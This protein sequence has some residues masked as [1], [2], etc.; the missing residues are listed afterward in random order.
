MEAL[1]AAI[2]E[3]DFCTALTQVDTLART[4]HDPLIPMYVNSIKAC[5]FA[6]SGHPAAYAALSHAL[7]GMTPELFHYNASNLLLV[8]RVLGADGYIGHRLPKD[9]PCSLSDFPHLARYCLATRNYAGVD[10]LLVQI[11]KISK[12]FLGTDPAMTGMRQKEALAVMVSRSVITLLKDSVDNISTRNAI[13]LFKLA[14]SSFSKQILP[15]IALFGKQIPHSGVECIKKLHRQAPSSMVANL[16][17]YDLVLGLHSEPGDWAPKLLM[18]DEM[19][20]GIQDPSPSG[21]PLLESASNLLGRLHTVRSLFIALGHVNTLKDAKMTVFRHFWKVFKVEHTLDALLVCEAVDND[22]WLPRCVIGVLYYG[23]N[24]VDGIEE[25]DL[26]EYQSLLTGPDAH[27]STSLL[28]DDTLLQFLILLAHTPFFRQEAL[29]RNAE[30]LPTEE[31]ERETSGEMAVRID[32]I[33]AVKHIIRTLIDRFQASTV[34]SAILDELVKTILLFRYSETG[35]ELHNMMT[36]LEYVI[37][38]DERYQED[39]ILHLVHT[40][41]QVIEIYLVLGWDARGAVLHPSL[42]ALLD[43]LTLKSLQEA[44]NMIATAISDLLYR[45]RDFNFHIDT[46][47]ITT[48]TG[49]LIAC[50]NLLQ[51]RQFQELVL[52][53]SGRCSTPDRQARD[54]SINSSVSSLQVQLERSAANIQKNIMKED[55]S[56]EAQPSQRSSSPLLMVLPEEESTQYPET[57]A[58]LTALLIHLSRYARLMFEH[59]KLLYTTQKGVID[60]Y[61]SL[62]LVLLV[63]KQRMRTID[64]ACWR[65]R[66]EED[67]MFTFLNIRNQSYLTLGYVVWTWYLEM[68]LL[69]ERQA[70][71]VFDGLPDVYIEEHRLK[72]KPSKSTRGNKRDASVET[73]Q[74]PLGS[75]QNPFLYPS[76]YIEM[77]SGANADI[78]TFGFVPYVQGAAQY[79]FEFT[80][81]VLQGLS[82]GLIETINPAVLLDGLGAIARAH[83]SGSAVLA[84]ALHG[85]YKWIGTMLS[86]KSI[87][88]QNLAS[89]FAGTSGPRT[90]AERPLSYSR[91]GSFL[92]DSLDL[93]PFG[94]MSFLFDV[95]GRIDEDVPEME[96][97][98]SGPIPVPDHPLGEEDGKESMEERVDIP[99]A[100]SILPMSN[101]ILTTDFWKHYVQTTTIPIQA[102]S[103]GGLLLRRRPNLSKDPGFSRAL[104]DGLRRFLY[105][106]PGTITRRMSRSDSLGTFLVYHLCLHVY[107]VCN[108][109]AIE[110]NSCELGE[111]FRQANALIDRK[112]VWDEEA[113]GIYAEYFDYHGLQHRLPPIDLFINIPLVHYWASRAGAVIGSCIIPEV[114]KLRSCDFTVSLPLVLALASSIILLEGA[115]APDIHQNLERILSCLSEK[116]VHPR[117]ETSRNIFIACIRNLLRMRL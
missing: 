95:G 46:L 3:H 30:C 45:G 47:L 5:I 43:D 106:V 85:L 7:T 53:R 96:R 98:I 92:I 38:R 69:S 15:N 80:T 31:I 91:D 8:C 103:V 64:T 104:G 37:R 58:N 78:R 81:D 112:G 113:P 114:I 65:E 90:S 105:G 74:F 86:Y 71:S 59:L 83:L 12:K 77:A 89:A 36:V 32:V 33:T 110:A 18:T 76:N 93:N 26:N 39:N 11:D 107:L 94:L 54:F 60:A 66:I 62:P 117:Q 21:R 101:S 57:Q 88:K 23:L 82:L 49:M 6:Y 108:G 10:K 102:A 13:T 115:I 29:P 40:Y 87:S 75:S 100:R 35:L 97:N 14:L 50:L 67:I 44:A 42:Q 20:M 79:P 17:E 2:D 34:S 19:L 4:S 109:L 111:L 27:A 73:P 84:Q 16:L 68:G 48:V 51:S 22:L 63:L 41:L 116:S 28:T 25:S 61:P 55:P 24:E 1:F 56:L 72:S 70:D 99:P 52:P 9:L